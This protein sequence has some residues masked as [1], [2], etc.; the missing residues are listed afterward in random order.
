MSLVNKD[1]QELVLE[2]FKTLNPEA[3]INLGGSK[4]MTV[5]ELISHVEKGDSFGARAIEA[6]MMMIKVLAG[7]R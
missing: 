3:K 6:Q 5:R 4:E 2:R 1:T 7:C